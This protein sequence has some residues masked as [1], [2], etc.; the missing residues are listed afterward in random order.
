MNKR[1][2]ETIIIRS[3]D[4]AW[5]LLQDINAG[6]EFLPNLELRFEGWPVFEMRLQGKDWDSTVPTRV[7]APLLS[8]QKDIYRTLM[9]IRH[10]RA[11]LRYLTREDKDS[12]ELIVRVSQG[13]SD[14]KA[15]LHDVLN[16]LVKEAILKM[17]S[18]DIARTLI[19]AALVYGG[20]EI[21]KAWMSS[22]QEAV[23]AEQTMEL[24]RQESERL[25]IFE[26]VIRQAPIAI[27]A[28]ADYEASK[29]RLLKVAKPNDTIFLP[30]VQLQGYEAAELVQTERSRSEDIDIHGIFR[31]LG[32]D[33]SDKISFQIKVARLSD[34]LTFVA[35]VSPELDAAKKSLIQEAEWS[36][37]KRLVELHI[38]A[39]ILHDSI[40]DASIYDVARPSEL[41]TK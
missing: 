15:S 17:E 24:S 3:A 41:Q 37:G 11:S 26:H 4:D 21:N 9:L 39:S 29:S 12:L 36:L 25:K 10:G 40:H 16:K 33:V 18:K 6:R 34:G 13:S 22:R 20:I 27:E 14:Y 31:I 28:Q 2:N 7:M 38:S 19:C 5:Q 35:K 32:N 1:E 8:V 30:G 23:R